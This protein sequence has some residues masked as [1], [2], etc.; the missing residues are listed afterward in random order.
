MNAIVRSECSLLLVSLGHRFFFV[1]EV[2]WNIGTSISKSKY[3]QIYLKIIQKSVS[4]ISVI[5]S[6]FKKKLVYAYM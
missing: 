3:E 4:T 1:N 5:F 6:E 2:R